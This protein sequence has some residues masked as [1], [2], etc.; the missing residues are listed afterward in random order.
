MINCMSTVLCLLGNKIVVK[1]H[2]PARHGKASHVQEFN[3]ELTPDYVQDDSYVQIDNKEMKEEAQHQMY[4][5]LRVSILENA[6]KGRSTTVIAYGQTGAGKTYTISGD[7][8]N[9]GRGLM[10][11]LAYELMQCLEEECMNGQCI[12]QVSYLEIY[13]EKIHDLLDD[14][15]YWTENSNGFTGPDSFAYV[16][17]LQLGRG[18]AVERSDIQPDSIYSKTKVLRVREHPGKG[19]YVEGL[20]WKQKSTASMQGNTGSSMACVNLVDLA[21]TEKLQSMSGERKNE[22]KYINRSLC[23]LNRHHTILT[24]KSS[25]LQ[26]VNQLISNLSKSTY[27]SYRNCALTWLL[28]DTLRGNGKTFLIA[29]ISPAEKDFQETLNTLRYAFKAKGIQN[30]HVDPRKH[31]AYK[32]N[33]ENRSL[34][35]LN[36]TFTKKVRDLWKHSPLAK[37]VLVSSTTELR[38]GH[39]WRV[40]I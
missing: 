23:Q 13:Q 20:I 35:S 6:L 33:D 30:I 24:I 31:L 4:Q 1:E 39:K 7:G 37:A 28:R 15:L 25:M 29:N 8:T 18:I 2:V 26:C 3:E 36:T 10:P 21:G 19:P 16:S 40:G 11:R 14:G 27:V 34:N 17:N 5:A 38:I 32:L 9:E 22:L 12:V